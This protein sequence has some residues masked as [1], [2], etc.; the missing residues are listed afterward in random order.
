M[1]GTALCSRLGLLEE[2]GRLKVDETL[3]PSGLKNV[4]VAGD[5]AALYRMA[6]PFAKQYAAQVVKNIRALEREEPITPFKP[7]DYGYVVGLAEGEG[8]GE[9]M[10]FPMK[11]WYGFAFHYFMCVLTLLG[12]KNK[13]RLLA[14]FWK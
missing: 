10:G 12:F 11:G 3:R 4:F 6:V 14:S 7:K 9:I 13:L 5:A 1:C 8:L 2:R